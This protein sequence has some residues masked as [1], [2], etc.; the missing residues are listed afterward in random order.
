M[1]VE[2]LT[3]KIINLAGRYDLE[4]VDEFTTKDMTRIDIAVL[5][6]EDRVLAVEFERTYKWI[7]RRILYNGIKAHRADFRNVFFVYPFKKKSVQNSWVIDFL[8]DLGMN[9]ELIH[10]DNCVKKITKL[11]HQKC[12][13]T[14]TESMNAGI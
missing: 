1:R 6:G 13:H 4:V 3:P 5:N 8:E 7:R 11:I 10:P 12:C 9:V 14:K 2:E